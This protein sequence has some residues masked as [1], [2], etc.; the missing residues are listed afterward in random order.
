[1]NHGSMEQLQCRPPRY[2]I[3]VIMLSLGF[4]TIA[5]R[6]SP[7]R[8]CIW[9]VMNPAAEEDEDPLVS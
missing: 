1:M 8:I 9:K 3:V 2:N 6:R 4:K 7:V 5:D